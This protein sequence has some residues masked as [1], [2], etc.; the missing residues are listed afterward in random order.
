MLLFSN[1]RRFGLVWNFT[2]PDA[3]GV[4]WYVNYIWIPIF[5]LNTPNWLPEILPPGLNPWDLNEPLIPPM[6]HDIKITFH[7]NS[8]QPDQY[9]HDDHLCSRTPGP[10]PVATTVDT[11]VLE[12]PWHLFCS[13]LDF[14]V[15]E[16]VLNPKWM[17]FSPSSN[18]VSRN[19]SNTLWR[20]TM[21]LLNIGI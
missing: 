9:I 14:E 19:Q 1:I 3:G 21:S 4:R 20:I 6:L 17:H 16:F 8:H 7:P 5:D 18:I 2:I 13:Y 10:E 15:A 11:P 12:K